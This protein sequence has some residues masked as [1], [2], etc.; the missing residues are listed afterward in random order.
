MPC[1]AK[2][3]FRWE[4]TIDDESHQCDVSVRA[5][6]AAERGVPF[7][8]A[9]RTELKIDAAQPAVDVDALAREACRRA[10]E[11]LSLPGVTQLH[12]RSMCA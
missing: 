2:L 1:K 8:A 3:A 7:P 5:D 4:I 12:C 10:R 9:W 11:E 6:H